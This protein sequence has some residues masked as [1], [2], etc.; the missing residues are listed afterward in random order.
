MRFE[1]SPT[2]LACGSPAAL[3]RGNQL[4]QIARVVEETEVDLRPAKFWSDKDKKPAI[5][6][7]LIGAMAESINACI[8][9]V[10]V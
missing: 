8:G 1:N 2:R 4:W 5:L 3:L 10:V 6:Q 9:G 7:F